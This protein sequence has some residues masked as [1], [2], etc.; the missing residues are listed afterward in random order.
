MELKGIDVS[1]HNG[2]INWKQVKDSGV[3]FVF[4]RAAVG[5]NKGTPSIDIKF[6]ENIEGAYAVGLKIGVYLYSY[7]QS[8]ERVSEEAKFMINTITPYKSY[9]TYPVVYD[10]EDN[11]QTYLGKKT[12]TEMV[13][14]FCNYVRDSGYIPMLYS[15]PNWLNNYIDSLGIGVDVWLAQWSSKPTWSGNF[16]VWQY[17][18]KGAVPGISGNVDLNIA[19]YDYGKIVEE[20]KEP[21]WVKE[22]KEAWEKATVKGVLDGTNPTAQVTREQLAV[23]LD[24]IGL[25]KES[26]KLI[27]PPESASSGMQNA[28]IKAYKQ[29]I[30]DGTRP[31]EYITREQLAVVLDRIGLLCN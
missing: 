4:I 17:S 14:I 28:W 21:D 27:M 2:V 24:R 8:V 19:Y 25:L 1:K 7:A 29:G 9:I 23:V 12:L 30:L 20:V 3:E 22:I 16:T 6:K 26:D 5:S 18:S 31:T 10:L 15:N 11:S 13:R